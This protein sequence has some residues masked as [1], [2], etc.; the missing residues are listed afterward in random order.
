MKIANS[1]MNVRHVLFALLLLLVSLPVFA[2][3]TPQQVV[4]SSIDG[5]MG[6]IEGR[7]DYFA[8]NPG[9]L[10]RV[11]DQSVSGVLDFRYI[12]ASVM[13]RYFNNAT[14]EQRTRFVNVFK[15]SLLDTYAKGL[16]TYDYREIRVLDNGPSRYE[17]QATVETQIIGTD[18]A[19]YPVN[20][21][22]RNSQGQWKVVNVIVN[23][24]NLGLTFRNQ[25]DESMR[26]HNR[27]YDAV[28][29]NWSP[30]VGA[31]ELE[32]GA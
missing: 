26:Q 11:V 28:I 21:T 6:Q 12:G 7:K 9:E 10:K 5:L 20:Y 32:R 16:I 18:G 23:G 15:Q 30:G 22:L 14:P 19:V 1:P 4:Q 3:Q 24:I 17:D 2:Q 29:S 8:S 25:F 27:D 31:D 13:G